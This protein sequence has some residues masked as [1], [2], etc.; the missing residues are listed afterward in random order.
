MQRTF[1]MALAFVFVVSSARA[2]GL[3]HPTRGFLAK[4]RM[5]LGTAWLGGLDFSPDG[6]PIVYE[7]ESGEIRLYEAGMPVTLA[8]FTP[9]MLG[10]FLAVVPGAHEILFADG[11]VDSS[12]GKIYS[13]PLTGGEPVL[14][15]QVSLAY[16]I[17]FDGKGRGFISAL[18]VPDDNR[19]VLL[20]RDPAS[21][22]KDIVVGIPG[23]S[24]PLALDGAGNLYYGTADLTR[25][26]WSQWLVCFRREQIEAALAGEPLVFSEESIV[27]DELAGFCDLIWTG[28]T[29]VYSDLGFTSG[30]GT[31]YAIGTDDHYPVS[32]IATFEPP[33]GGIVFPSFLAFRGGAVPF[34]AGE[35]PDGGSM[36][37][38]YAH[39][40]DT[41][42]YNNVVEILPD[43]YFVRGRVNGDELVDLS[44]AV[45]LLSFLFTGGEAPDPR[46][47]GDVNDDGELDISDPIYLLDYLFRGGPPIP[48]PY[49]E[50]GLDES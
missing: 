45:S 3:C 20:D 27:R 22:N 40:S 41:E 30:T 43:Q 17:A 19:I 21:Q 50:P 12:G 8:R 1:W 24:G 42:V 49:P 26:P 23:G 14:V 33:V 7:P 44:D 10:A 9:G 38:Y 18:K 6:Q 37:V 39:Y 34:A 25:P 48:A 29:L 32:T 28:G 11:E 16:D 5:A 46:A 35:G 2:E 15:D 4:E 36:L 47:A 13:L 31:V